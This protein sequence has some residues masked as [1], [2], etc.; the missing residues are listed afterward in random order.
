MYILKRTL[1]EILDVIGSHPIES[2]GIIGYK[3]E[4]ICSFIFDDSF[5]SQYEYRPNVEYLNDEIQKWNSEGISFCGIVHSHLYGFNFPSESDRIYA[6]NL[7]T[8][9]TNITKLLFPIVTIDSI[10]EPHVVFFQ[11]SPETDSFVK[12]ALR[13]VNDTTYLLK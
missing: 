3:D 8:F 13:A 10:N 12:L 2:G 4:C 7:F 1:E 5:V 6:H 11:F 9:G